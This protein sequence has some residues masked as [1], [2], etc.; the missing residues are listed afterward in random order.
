MTP[1]NFH[2]E[3]PRMSPISSNV[4]LNKHEGARQSTDVGIQATHMSWYLL[5]C[6]NA[7]RSWSC[8]VGVFYFIFIYF[9]MQININGDRIVATRGK[10]PLTKAIKRLLQG[11]THALSHSLTHTCRKKSCKKKTPVFNTI[12]F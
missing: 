2:F 10:N 6:V 7:R 5:L 3:P 9:L 4:S 11:Y 1:L 12:N 8:Y